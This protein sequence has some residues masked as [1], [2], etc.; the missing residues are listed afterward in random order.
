VKSINL[1]KTIYSVEMI[2]DEKV[3]IQTLG[4]KLIT[5]DKEGG[6]IEET[7]M[8]DERVSSRSGDVKVLESNGT[9]LISDGRRY[10]GHQH[11]IN[12]LTIIKNAIYTWIFNGSI[13]DREKKDG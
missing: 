9:I 12:G 6:I 13:V 11:G 10:E 7:S 2:E 4:N 3:W 5:M 8:G 1:K